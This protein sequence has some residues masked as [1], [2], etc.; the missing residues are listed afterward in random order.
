MFLESFINQKIQ[1]KLKNF[2]EHLTG[3]MTGIYEP[4]AWYTVK[5]V[6]TE[7][8]GIWVE[9]P[10]H[11]RVKIQEESEINRFPSLYYRIGPKA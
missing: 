7:S 1:I 9:N 4:E 3:Q 8:L 10:C 6:K 5:L 2:P 11:K